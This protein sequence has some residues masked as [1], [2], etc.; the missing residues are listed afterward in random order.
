[1]EIIMFKSDDGTVTEDHFMAKWSQKLIDTAETVG[2]SFQI[3]Y[4]SCE[5]ITQAGFINVTERKYKVP[6]GPWSSDPRTRE[7]GQW[8]LL[9]YLQG[10]ESWSLYLLTK[11][12]HV[13]DLRK[14]FLS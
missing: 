3:Y 14:T 12:L 7:L 5:Y 4:H 11:V 6:V 2:K 1:M 10:L 13:R 9:F 8:N